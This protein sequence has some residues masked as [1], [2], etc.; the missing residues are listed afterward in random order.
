MAERQRRRVAEMP[1]PAKKWKFLKEESV[2]WFHA[3][4]E[5]RANSVGEEP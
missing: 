1:S 2:E 4:V 3:C 5:N